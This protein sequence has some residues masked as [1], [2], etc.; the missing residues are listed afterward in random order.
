MAKPFTRT[1]VEALVSDLQR[2]MDQVDAGDLDATIA[3]RH[4]IEGAVS[5]LKVALGEAELTA[6][7]IAKDDRLFLGYQV[8]NSIKNQRIDTDIELACEG[9]VRPQQ[10]IEIRLAKDV[11]MTI[12]AV[13]P[14]NV[15]ESLPH[16]SQFGITANDRRRNRLIRKNCAAVILS[17]AVIL[18]RNTQD[19][20]DGSSVQ[21]R[22]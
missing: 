22:P 2:L 19:R 17:Q 5:A 3:M 21:R 11:R 20:F 6:I 13:V 1:Q 16:D 12:L 14:T 4:R 15:L 18:R 9:Q 10:L 7:E 8:V